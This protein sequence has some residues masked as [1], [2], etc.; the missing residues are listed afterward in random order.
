MKTK[1]LEEWADLYEKKTGDKLDRSQKATFYFPDKGFGVYSVADDMIV[2]LHVCGDGVFWRQ[3]GEV[4]AIERGLHKLGA[5][6]VRKNIKAYLR[7]FDMKITNEE[8]LKDGKIRYF[9][10]HKHTGKLGRATPTNGDEYL[11]TWEV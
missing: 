4:L 7:C 8:I 3:I 9:F 2:I 6:C 11:I 10:E 1:T 5:I